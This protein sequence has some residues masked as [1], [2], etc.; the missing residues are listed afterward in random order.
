MHALRGLT[1]PHRFDYPRMIRM[2][3]TGEEDRSRIGFDNTL[4]GRMPVDYTATMKRDLEE[5]VS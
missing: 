1:L 4:S 5:Q 2:V 3:G